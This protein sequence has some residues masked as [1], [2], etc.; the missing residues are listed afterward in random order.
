MSNRTTIS[1]ITINASA[2]RIWD[3]ITKPELVKQWQYG[4]DLITN[5]QVGSPIVFRNEW[6]GAVFEQKGTI[7][8]VKPQELVKY[9]LFFPHPDLEDKPEN[10]FTMTY[11]LEDTSD[12]TT[13]TIIQDD[14]REMPPQESSE[15]G[16]N[17]VG[18]ESENNVLTTLKRLIEG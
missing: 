18:E 7:L 13:L 9:T 6:E 8:E 16:E 10:Y 4:S 2:A 5:W 3:A 1:K 15:E 11:L 12:Q 14:P 17:G